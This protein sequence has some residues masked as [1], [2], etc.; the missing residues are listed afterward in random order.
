MFK[1]EGNCD[2]SSNNNEFLWVFVATILNFVGLF[3]LWQ[4][5]WNFEYEFFGS[6]LEREF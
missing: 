1:L 2:F 4:N 6:Q 3:L 5:D